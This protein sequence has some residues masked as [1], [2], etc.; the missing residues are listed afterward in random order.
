MLILK[1]LEKTFIKKIEQGLKDIDEGRYQSM[2][3]FCA[4]MEEKY[5]LKR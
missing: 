2:E 5:D 3:D 1:V 4:E